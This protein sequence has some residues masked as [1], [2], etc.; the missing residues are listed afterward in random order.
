MASDEPVATML[1]F[2]LDRGSASVE[3]SAY[4]DFWLKATARTWESCLRVK[5]SSEWNPGVMGTSPIGTS[6]AAGLS[7]R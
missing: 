2:S 7:L 1:H 5:R 4:S 6:T 3:F